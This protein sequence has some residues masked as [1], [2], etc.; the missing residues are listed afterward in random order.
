MNQRCYLLMRV[1]LAP[2]FIWFGMLKPLGM[3]PE[4]APLII[5]NVLTLNS[6]NNSVY[7]TCLSLLTRYYSVFLT[8]SCLIITFIG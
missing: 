5:N 8:S 3:S 6:L 2:S 7:L 4:T 1:A